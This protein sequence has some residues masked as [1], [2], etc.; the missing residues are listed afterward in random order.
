MDGGARD[1][2]LAIEHDSEAV[3]RELHAD[4]LC[5]GDQ[6]RVLVIRY[7]DVDLPMTLLRRVRVRAGHSCLIKGWVRGACLRSDREGVQGK[8]GAALTCREGKGIC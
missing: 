7:T 1:F 6:S 5:V 3:A 2:E 4:A 8:S